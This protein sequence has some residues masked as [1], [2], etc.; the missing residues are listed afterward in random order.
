M[1]NGTKVIILPKATANY[2]SLFKARLPP[3]AKP[4]DEKLYT[5]T[6]TYPKAEADKVLAPVRKAVLEVAEAK[7]PGKGAAIVRGMKWPVIADGDERLST[8]GEPMFPGEMFIVA[9]RKESFGPP[10]I[11]DGNLER[12]L[13]AGRVYSGAF[14]LVQ[15]NLYPFHHPLGGNGVG[16]G[17]ANVQV[18]GGGVRRDG[19]VE[20]EDAFDPVDT[21]DDGSD[22]SL[23]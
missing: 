7:W 19:R 13:D 22:E 17:L 5:V 4:T 3:N 2:V 9:K 11:V 14:M 21:G 23:V 8:D 12:V 6:L 20:P 16:V 10:G 18:L 1:A 15:V